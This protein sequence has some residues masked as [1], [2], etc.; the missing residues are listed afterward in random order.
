MNNNLKIN[1]FIIFTVLITA[2][3]FGANVFEAKAQN[4]IPPGSYQASCI[5]IK[6]VQ[7]QLQATCN[8][9]GSNKW[10]VANKLDDFFLCVDDIR[11]DDG[12]IKCTKSENSPLMKKADA[13]FAAVYPGVFGKEW[14][15]SSTTAYVRD[16]FKE[17][18]KNIITNFFKGLDGAEA[19]GYLLD[20]TRRPENNGIR[21]MIVNRAFEYVYGFRPQ[22][23][24]IA[25]WNAKFL[26]SGTTYKL[27]ISEELDKLNKPDSQGKNPVRRLMINSVYKK[28][29][30]RNAKP[31]D[32]AYWEKRP[33]GF[34]QI[35]AAARTYLY[36]SKGVTDLTETITR[37]LTEKSNGKP[38]SKQDLNDAL[39]KHTPKKSIYVEMLY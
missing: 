36:S 25:Y 5:D 16:M 15:S 10:T 12:V 4:G 38:P 18:R 2:S 1:K 34:E 37:A 28:A 19:R 9:K 29:M 31:E 22:T 27:I 32:Y 39:F 20:L 6:V 24:A 21:L 35:I 3:L 23:A 30:G 17:N 13:S 8:P 14:N 7:T 33:E 11:N 26:E